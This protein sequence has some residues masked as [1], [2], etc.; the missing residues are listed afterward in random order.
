MEEREPSWT[1]RAELTSN[2][3]LPASVA[4][5]VRVAAWMTPVGV[6]EPVCVLITVTKPRALAR[7]RLVYTR[8]VGENAPAGALTAVRTSRVLS[9]ATGTANP[10]SAAGVEP[11]PVIPLRLT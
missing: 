9:N 10:P 11:E 3:T 7:S 6:P 8:S 2:S 1:V 4:V 5:N